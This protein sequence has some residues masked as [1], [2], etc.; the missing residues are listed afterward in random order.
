M[1]VATGLNRARHALLAGTGLARDKYPVVFLGATSCTC[2]MTFLIA[3]VRP[4]M[5][6]SGSRS[7][8]AS[9]RCIWRAGELREGERH[10]WLRRRGLTVTPLVPG[11]YAEP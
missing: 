6:S 5:R 2:S 10:S 11:G 4:R 1:P 8:A 3:E 9:G 7:L